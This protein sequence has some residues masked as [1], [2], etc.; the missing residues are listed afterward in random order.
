MKNNKNYEVSID[1]YLI[2]GRY[3]QDYGPEYSI[4]REER[5]YALFLYNVLRAYSKGIYSEKTVGEDISELENILKLCG[6]EGMKINKIYY[7]ATFMRDFFERDRRLGYCKEAYERLKN[8]DFSYEKSRT[9]ENDDN[10]KSFNQRLMEYVNEHGKYGYDVIGNR[11]FHGYM[12]L[13]MGSSMDVDEQYSKMFAEIKYMMNS[14]PDIAV[15]C[16]KDGRKILR[17]IEC[18]F[19]SG[20][21]KYGDEPQTVIQSKIADFICNDLCKE[22]FNGG[23]NDCSKASSLVTFTRKE[24]ET[25][26]IYIRNLLKLESYIWDR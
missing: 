16:E 10:S 2:E 3:E 6:L 19:E 24:T 23:N 5:Q 15:V 20:E 17:F 4:C 13:H 21:S 9:V 25:S 8:K 18:K 14:K 22:Y 11:A 12:D 7:E 26:K 1:N